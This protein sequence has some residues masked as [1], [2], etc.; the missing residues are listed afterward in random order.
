MATMVILPGWGH[1]SVGWQQFAARFSDREVRILDLPG[2]GVE[3]LVSAEWG[4]PEYVDWVRGR[5]EALRDSEVILLGHSFG[6]RI[7]AQLASDHPVWL[8]GVM[9]YG[10]PCLYRPSLKI[11][12]IK[13]IARVA[14]R[15]G[16]PRPRWV[17]SELTDAD[18]T[19]VGQIYRKAVGFDQGAVLPRITVPTALVW[20]E[21]DTYAPVALAR[22]MQE[23]VPHATLTVLPGL[24]HNVHVE[25]ANLFYGTIVKILTRMDV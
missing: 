16:I 4:I 3:P 12:V 14:K 22:E 9:L 15:L 5:I 17:N 24:G 11:R 7:A 8:K 23:L 2:F 1:T 19:G 25:N 6:G 10:A 20:G 18:D 13:M 21:N